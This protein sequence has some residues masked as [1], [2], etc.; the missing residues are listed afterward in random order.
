LQQSFH[1]SDYF[2]RD[3]TLLLLLFL[4]DLNFWYSQVD[5]STLHGAPYFEMYAFI[6]CAQYMNITVYCTSDIFQYIFTL[7][8]SS[9]IPYGHQNMKS[10]DFVVIFIFR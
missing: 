1:T 10:I 4:F 6:H 7:A 3:S 9:L 2:A 8:R 5:V